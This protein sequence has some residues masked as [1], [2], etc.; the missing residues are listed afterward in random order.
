MLYNLPR[1]DQ[2]SAKTSQTSLM[3]LSLAI[4][5]PYGSLRTFVSPHKKSG[6]IRIFVIVSSSSVI[7]KGLEAAKFYTKLIYDGQR[8]ASSPSDRSSPI[9]HLECKIS[10]VSAL[11]LCT[12]QQ[13]PTGTPGCN[14]FRTW[15]RRAEITYCVL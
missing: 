13:R 10:L 11:D 4:G 7:S 2:R 14:I 9:P 1:N 3:D 6:E 12:N 15:R 5:T 8:C